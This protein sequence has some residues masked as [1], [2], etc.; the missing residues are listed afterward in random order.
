MQVTGRAS[1]ATLVRLAVIVNISEL[2]VH[3]T[4]EQMLADP[5]LDLIDIFL[6]PH[7]HVE[8]ACKALA[9]GKHVL[10]EKPLG[11]TTAE[12]DEIMRAAT[13]AHR[14]VMVAQVLPYMG[15]FEFAFPCRSRWQ[16]RQADQRL[17]QACDIASGLDSR[18]L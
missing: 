2:Q 13:A 7:L 1:K 9:A 3:E 12:C 8:A 4:L 16:V 10:C 17:L 18:F 14:Q 5:E 11:L 15:E 6:P